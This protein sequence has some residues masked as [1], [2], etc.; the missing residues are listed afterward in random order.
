VGLVRTGVPEKGV[1]SIFRVERAKGS[2]IQEDDILHSHLCETIRSYMREFEII[3][4]GPRMGELTGGWTNCMIRSFMA[5]NIPQ[6][7]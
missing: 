4:F 7:N 2:H 1:I 6:Y 5:P 3:L